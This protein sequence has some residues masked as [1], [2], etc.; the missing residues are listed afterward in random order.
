VPHLTKAVHPTSGRQQERRA[1][2]KAAAR[3]RATARHRW[4][5]LL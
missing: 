3:V 4:Y 5:P 1:S 2:G